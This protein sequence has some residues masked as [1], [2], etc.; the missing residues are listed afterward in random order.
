MSGTVQVNRT[1]QEKDDTP[2]TEMRTADTASDYEATLKAFKGVDAVIHLAAIPDP[3]D[4]DDYKVHNNNVNSAFIGLRAC[5]ELKINRVT[6]ASS[7]NAIGLAFSNQP[8]RFDYFPLDEK[9]VQR[10]TDSYAL[11]KME[12]EIQCESFVHWFPDMR[13]ASLRIHEV[14]PLKTVQKEH[15]EDP[16]FA[17]KQLWAWV[18]PT[19]VA[20]ACMLGVTSEG[21]KGHEVF[22]IVAPET[23]QK[24]PSKELASK[25]Y[26]NTQLR[27]GFDG[28]KAFF[29]SQKAEKLLGWTH[30]E[31]E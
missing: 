13:I 18:N 1:D 9:V 21:W 3:V 23:T 6:F 10:P 5:A 28:N 24:T 12:A 4:K 20:R 15:E 11:A 30:D 2:N 8:N 25:H 17:A 16:E 19:A 29:I 26:P 31:K 7:V 14:Q 27:D 22:N